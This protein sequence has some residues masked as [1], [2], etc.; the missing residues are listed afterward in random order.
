MRDPRRLLDGDASELERS[1]LGAAQAETAPAA[2]QERLLAQ[3]G[4]GAL[5]A[6]LS[7]PASA[8]AASSTSLPPAAGSAVAASASGLGGKLL[9]TVLI[10]SLAGAGV[11]LGT[12]RSAPVPQPRAT[13]AAASAPSTLEAIAPTPPGEA[14]PSPEPSAQVTAP[15]ALSREVAELTSVR[16]QLRAGD[17][18]AALS[19]LVTFAEAHP[20]SVLAQEADAL[21]IEALLLAG[22]ASAARVEAGRFLRAHP[23]SPHTARLKALLGATPAER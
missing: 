1:L 6:G 23:H 4:L 22:Q 5:A 16:A 15:S 7:L 12:S 17:A 21:R 2:A 8:H 19:A 9:L 18:R 10:G 11:W 14:P 3:L 20:R 13:Q